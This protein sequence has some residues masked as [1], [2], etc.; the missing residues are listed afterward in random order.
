MFESDADRLALI[1]G[2]GGLLVSHTA[3]EFWAIFENEYATVLDGAVESTGPA[4]TAR[5]SDVRN[6]PKDTVLQVG[7][8]TYRVKTLQPDG[9]GMTAILLKG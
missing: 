4:V 6:I 7:E 2:L 8:D 9:L 1:K 5:T 3:G